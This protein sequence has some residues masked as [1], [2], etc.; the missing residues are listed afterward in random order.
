MKKTLRA[1]FALMMAIVMM[2][3]FAACESK[4]DK[5]E[6]EEKTEATA[7]A[8][9]EDESATD[10]VVDVENAPAS[11]VIGQVKGNTYNNE[12]FDI[13]I[14]LD[15]NWTFYND[16]QIAQIS[17][18]ALDSMG[19]DFAEIVEEAGVLYLMYAMDAESGNNITA[20]AEKGA[21]GYTAEEIL[22][23]QVE[24]L[25]A[26]YE[27]MGATDVVINP[28]TTKVG[29]KK[30]VSCDA[31]CQIYGMTLNQKLL[32]ITRNDYVIALTV[33]AMN[34]GD[35]DTILKNIEL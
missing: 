15:D 11:D 16:E 32:I 21:D 3:S 10:V 29:G 18:I 22:D 33:T 6:D 4:K 14:S 23:L 7:A 30:I 35:I 28:G 13:K 31:Q 12:Y 9:V 27:S 34:D 17:G 26:L 8:A 19:D 1:I 5:D 24:N 20:T 2:L 25:P